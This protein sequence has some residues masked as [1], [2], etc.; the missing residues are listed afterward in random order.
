MCSPLNRKS[1]V[2]SEYADGFGPSVTSFG[3]KCVSC[4]DAWYGMPLFLLLNFAPITVLYLLILV[5]QTSITSAPM[6]CFVMY[7]EIVAKLIDSDKSIWIME[8]FLT[9]NCD[10]RSDMQITLTLYGIFNLDFYHFNIPLQ[11]YCVSSK[12]KFIHIAMFG[13]IIAF[14]PI[15]LI[16]LT[17]VCIELHGHN[18]R[19]LVWLWRPFH[20]CFVRLQRG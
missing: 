8:I 13:Y 12:L 11:P 18:F 4:T 20:R 3:Y 19:P 16:C 7:A 1:L 17:W 9:D 10:I 15:L 2:C 14:Y 5:F 6:P